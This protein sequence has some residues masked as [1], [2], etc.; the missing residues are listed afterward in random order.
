MGTHFAPFWHG[1]FEHGVYEKNEWIFI[2]YMSSQ[3]IMINC[4]TRAKML[5]NEWRLSRYGT[6]TKL[7]IYHSWFLYILLYC[8][9]CWRMTESDMVSCRPSTLKVC[10]KS[11]VFSGLIPFSTRICLYS[12]RVHWTEADQDRPLLLAR[13]ASEHDE[14]VGE[15]LSEWVG[16]MLTREK[17]KL[18]LSRTINSK[19][20]FHVI[21]CDTNYAERSIPLQGCQ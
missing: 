21:P 18:R 3:V 9:E 17:I 15:W 10:E 6:S 11:F 5:N 13:C 14:W 19:L 7:K 20:C 16:D 12:A 1:E 4:G 8:S 2:S